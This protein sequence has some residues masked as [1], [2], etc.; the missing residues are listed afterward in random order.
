MEW[1]NVRIVG[2][3]KAEIVNVCRIVYECWSETDDVTE[4]ACAVFWLLLIYLSLVGAPDDV[5]NINWP[6]TLSDLYLSYCGVF[7]RVM[8]HIITILRIKEMVCRN[9]VINTDYLISVVNIYILKP[10][11]GKTLK[12]SCLDNTPHCLLQTGPN[13]GL[14]VTYLLLWMSASN[15]CLEIKWYSTPSLSDCLLDLEVSVA[16]RK[17]QKKMPL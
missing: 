11:H 5:L 3:R 13:K 9:L 1:K 6:P 14:W 4:N 2:S 12:L 16:N 15:E 7:V 8:L 10:N 17:V